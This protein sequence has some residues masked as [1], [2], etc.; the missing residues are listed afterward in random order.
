VRPANSTQ[1]RDL[2]DTIAR[3]ATQTAIAIS[4]AITLGIEPPSA[5]YF[6]ERDLSR[7]AHALHGT[8]LTRPS[9]PEGSRLVAVAHLVAVADDRDPTAV[10]E[11][12]VRTAG[13]VGAGWHITHTTTALDPAVIFTDRRTTK[14]GGR[15]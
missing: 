7:W 3:L 12:I 1:R 8:N 2:G 6:A 14:Q 11:A 9:L 13:R 15:A 4:Q 10:A 5:V